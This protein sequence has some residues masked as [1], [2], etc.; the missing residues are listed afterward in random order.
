MTTASGLRLMG[1]DILDSRPWHPGENAIFV[2]VEGSGADDITAPW[3]K[4]AD[5]A[6]ILQALAPSQWSP[7]YGMLKDRFGIT[8]VFSI[9]QT[10]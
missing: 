9:A 2:V 1:F 6:T 8:W 10:A 3:K 5:S 4:L 7:L